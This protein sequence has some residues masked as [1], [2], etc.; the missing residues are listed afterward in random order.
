[1]P[2][3]LDAKVKVTRYIL[4]T[5]KQT[6]SAD[7]ANEAERLPCR[8]AAREARRASDTGPDGTRRDPSE[9]RVR[10]MARPWA[11]RTRRPDFRSNRRAVYEPLED[12]SARRPGRD[13]VFK[14]QL[15]AADGTETMVLKLLEA[16]VKH[17]GE[18]L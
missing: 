10:S 8:L 5:T 2:I 6:H 4:K 15:N 12:R 14:K 16:T 18:E 7:K 3:S 11:S 1:M 9:T 17:S 13:R